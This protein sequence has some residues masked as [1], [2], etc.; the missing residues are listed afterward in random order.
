MLNVL[1]LLATT[2]A[3]IPIPVRIEFKQSIVLNMNKALNR[4]FITRHN[5]L[6]VF[7]LRLICALNLLLFYSATGAQEVQE[8]EQLND[9]ETSTATGS[10]TPVPLS[11]PD[12]EAS[13]QQRLREELDSQGLVTLNANGKDFLGLW[14]PDTSG[15][16]IGAVLIFHAEGEHAN[17]PNTISVIREH[18][19]RFG[20]ATLS[21]S[22][23]NPSPQKPPTRPQ[24]QLPKPEESSEAQKTEGENT[25]QASATAEVSPIPEA[26]PEGPS[27][28]IEQII[29][30]RAQAAMD[31]LKNKGQ[32]NIVFVGYGLGAARAARFLDSIGNRVATGDL[33]KQLRKTKSKAV[34]SRPVR[35]LILVNARNHIP[36][37]ND[38]QEKALTD[39]LNDDSLPI[40][41]IYT[42][43]HYLDAFEPG[44]RKKA[45]RTKQ[46]SRYTQV[47]IGLL[48]T[49]DEEKENLLAKRVR[50]FLNKNAR[51]VRIDGR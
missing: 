41:D 20:W 1:P 49:T 31:Y 22:L 23:A 32:Y 14:Q 15:V 43:Y 40:L 18:L 24:T 21:I 44:A 33:D 45:A 6:S 38:P 48:T 26:K 9:T 12:T 35:A 19:A 30:A 51:G 2:V 27:K 3:V 17:W 8:G 34:I 29:Q 16:P 7:I 5:H 4:F 39:W 25:A 11:A 47:K 42:P 36:S 50:G 10:P 37:G 28:D 46:L 13:Q